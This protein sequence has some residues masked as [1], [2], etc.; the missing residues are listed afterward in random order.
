V[1]LCYGQL[2]TGTTKGNQMKTT[3]INISLG[4]G[5]L[6]TSLI[7]GACSSGPESKD[8]IE[9]MDDTTL[10][11]QESDA[12]WTGCVFSSLPLENEP[13]TLAEIQVF[14][15]DYYA[16]E[17][18]AFAYETTPECEARLDHELTLDEVREKGMADG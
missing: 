1:Q 8:C 3:L 12:V 11:A 6:G 15:D 16:D 13:V 17:E 10:T 14:A 2:I 18:C 7:M 9:W 4:L 5:V